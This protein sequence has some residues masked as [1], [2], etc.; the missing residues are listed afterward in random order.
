MLPGCD[1]L[2]TTMGLMRRFVY[3][4]IISI[5]S[6]VSHGRGLTRIRGVSLLGVEPKA[7]LPPI[8][9]GSGP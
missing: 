3:I 5:F 2:I 1:L 8:L 4:S 6:N 9:W 7:H